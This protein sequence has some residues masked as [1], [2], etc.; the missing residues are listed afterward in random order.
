MRLTERKYVAAVAEGRKT[1]SLRDNVHRRASA[2]TVLGRERTGEH[3]SLFHGFDWQVGED[4]LPSPEI[5]GVCAVDFEPRLPPSRTVRCE[6]I[7]IHKHIALVDRWTICGTE[8]GQIGNPVIEK[9][10]SPQFEN[11]PVS[12]PPAAH[13]FARHPRCRRP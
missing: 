1:S 6:Q 4:R 12:I 5:D 2:S 7:L 8:Q 11:Y 3:R 9:G 13:R 10:G